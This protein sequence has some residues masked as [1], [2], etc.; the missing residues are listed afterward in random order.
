MASK[1]A[2][3]QTQGQIKR[4]CVHRGELCVCYERH[5]LYSCNSQKSKKT[6]YYGKE[7]W[8][9]KADLEYSTVAIK[10]ERKKETIE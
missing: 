7:H 1:F 4:A 2:T 10:K 8:D 9:P 6:D 3:C 5:H